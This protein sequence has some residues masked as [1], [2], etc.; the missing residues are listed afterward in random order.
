MGVSGSLVVKIDVRGG[1]VIVTL[2]GH[3][4]DATAADLREH[5]VG[6]IG[7]G[8]RDVVVDLSGVVSIGPSALAVLI[9]AMARA[10]ATQSSIRYSLG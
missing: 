10:K 1:S 4:D 9:A 6:A 3:A 2:T 5:L 8:G 7:D